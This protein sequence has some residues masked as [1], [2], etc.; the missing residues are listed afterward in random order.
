MKWMGIPGDPR[1]IY[2][3]R[4]EWA[5]NSKQL[6]VE[7]L[8]RLQNTAELFLS[9]VSSGLSRTIFTD[10]DEAWADMN[11]ILPFGDKFIWLS[12]RDG[13][14]HA[15]LVDRKG[16]QP[17]ILTRGN[18]DVIGIVWNFRE[19]DGRSTVRLAR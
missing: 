2:I 3:P 4:M 14:R 15:Y 18:F 6:V 8:N 5:G 7:K 16:S 13:W 12:E 9:D 11:E 1:D 17:E 10:S 19:G